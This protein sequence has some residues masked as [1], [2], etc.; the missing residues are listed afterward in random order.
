MAVSEAV[1]HYLHHHHDEEGFTVASALVEVAEHRDVGDLP[2]VEEAEAALA[3]MLRR[4]DAGDRWY[5]AAYDNANGLKVVTGGK[6]KKAKKTKKA[7]KA[8]K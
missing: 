5:K 3:E 6:A 2:S 8:K 1:L 7:K 4:V